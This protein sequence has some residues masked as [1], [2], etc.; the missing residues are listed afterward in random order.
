[1]ERTPSTDAAGGSTTT[2]TDAAPLRRVRTV[3]RVM[4]EAFRIPGTDIRIGLDP[5][6]GILPVAG[7]GV[8]TIFSLYIVLEAAVAGVPRATLLRMLGVV[9]VDTVVGSVPVLGPLFDAAWKANT[10]NV[11]TLERHVDATGGDT[12]ERAYPTV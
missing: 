4:D 5:I 6:I 8:A 9:G 1:M 10:W 2:E 12:P 7:D 11:R 3:A